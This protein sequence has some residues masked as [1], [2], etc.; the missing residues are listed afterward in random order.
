MLDPAASSPFIDGFEF[1]SGGGGL[2]ST[3]TD[4]AKFCQ[5]LVDGGQFKG[6]RLLKPETVKLMFTDQL[7]GVG[8]SFK[9][10]LGF[11]I[12]EIKLGAGTTQR[13]TVQY[14]WGG[15]ASTEFVVVPSERLF[16]VFVRQQVPDTHD[17]ARKQFSIV[18]ESL[19]APSSAAAPI[20]SR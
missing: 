13:Q 19:T 3:V 8:G 2:L 9:F 14:S 17:L 15:Y 6:R 16:Q 12:N 4:Y 1:L 5:M 7:N 18:Y 10:G 20:P 11:A